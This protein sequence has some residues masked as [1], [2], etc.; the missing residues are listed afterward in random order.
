MEVKQC[1]DMFVFLC[2]HIVTEWNAVEN[3]N[4]V[5]LITYSYVNKH[6]TNHLVYFLTISTK[7]R[8]NIYYKTN[9][10]QFKST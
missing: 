5:T 9:R 7:P 8:T 6:G 1:Y 3:Y 4:R 2:F 10:V